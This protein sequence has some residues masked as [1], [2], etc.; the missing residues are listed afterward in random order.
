MF[1][2]RLGILK[3]L[4][5][6]WIEYQLSQISNGAPISISDLEFQLIDFSNLKSTLIVH[7]AVVH[8]PE[9]NDWKWESPLIARVGYVKVTANLWSLLDLPYNIKQSLEIRMNPIKDI[10]SLEMKD[11]QVFIEKRRNIFNFHLLDE[12]L[13]LPSAIDVLESLTLA[14]QKSSKPNDPQSESIVSATGT[15]TRTRTRTGNH[16]SSSVIK[17]ASYGGDAVTTTA[18]ASDEE[19]DAEGAKKADE[20]VKTIVGAVS[21]LGR[22]ANEGGTQAL[23]NALRNQKDGFVRLVN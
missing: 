14:Q 19:A 2:E 5:Q 22:A 10:Y 16:S 1:A 6:V 11:V 12:R 4:L 9:K 7:D 21:T 23:S 8:T 20:L 3:R 17:S 13:D 15:R 18:A